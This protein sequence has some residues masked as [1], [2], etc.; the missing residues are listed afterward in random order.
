ML[1]VLVGL[2]SVAG[3]ISWLDDSAAAERPG[4]ED[5]KLD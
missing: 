3:R 1:L 2:I 5:I 4:E